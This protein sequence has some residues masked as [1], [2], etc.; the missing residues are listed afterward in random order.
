MALIGGIFTLKILKSAATGTYNP[1]IPLFFSL[2]HLD[3]LCVCV[4]V[5]CLLQPPWCFG[6]LLQGERLGP[7]LF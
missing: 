5:M 7:S 6:T 4:S 1:F 2:S 3:G